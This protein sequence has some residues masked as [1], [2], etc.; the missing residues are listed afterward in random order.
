[1]QNKKIVFLLSVVM[2]IM[3]ACDNKQETYGKNSPAAPTTVAEADTLPLQQ[4]EFEQFVYEVKKEM[5][6]LEHTEVM[7]ILRGTMADIQSQLPTEV[8]EGMMIT[9]IQ[10]T[11]NAVAYYVLCNEEIIDMDEFGNEDEQ[12]TMIADI[13]QLDANDPENAL[14]TTICKVAGMDIVYDFMGDNSGKE[15]QIVIKKEDML[16]QFDKEASESQLHKH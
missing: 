14:F 2:T 11:E 10:I 12:K 8:V 6:G 5:E 3:S 9:D 7:D 16:K 1:M 4:D 15:Y 13:T